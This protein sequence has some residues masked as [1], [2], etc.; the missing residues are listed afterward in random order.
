MLP[1][2][3]QKL[4]RSP[5]L[6]AP[7]SARLV[8]L[9]PGGSCPHSACCWK[10][11]TGSAQHRCRRACRIQEFRSGAANP[12]LLFLSQ[13][14][15]RGGLQTA[16]EGTEFGSSWVHVS[17]AESY[18][19]MLLCIRCLI[20]LRRTEHWLPRDSPQ[21]KAKGNWDLSFDLVQTLAGYVI[22]AC[23]VFLLQDIFHL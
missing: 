20:V 8:T 2:P 17:I 4:G 14:L 3:W 22:W 23:N 21:R 19:K 18:W 12:D 15:C 1:I 5:V 16:P 6:R 11:E 9:L 7:S 13:D 10:L